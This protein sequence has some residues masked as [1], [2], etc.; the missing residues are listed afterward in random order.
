M[1]RIKPNRKRTIEFK[2]M[3]SPEEAELLKKKSEESG[4]SRSEVLRSLLIGRSI[5]GYRGKLYERTV[6]DFGSNFHMG[7]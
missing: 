1:M 7:G 2:V 3:L 5:T 6:T 4:L